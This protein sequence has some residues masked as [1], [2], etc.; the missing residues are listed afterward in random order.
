[1]KR[2]ELLERLERL[3]GYIREI[4][5]DLE[6]TRPASAQKG[7]VETGYVSTGKC[8]SC[9]APIDWYKTPNDKWI[10]KDEGTDTPHWESC[11]ERER[12]ARGNDI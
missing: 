12:F 7:K 11:P 5:Q 4:R 10:P 9:S 2:T 3:E 1:M 8:K 6:A